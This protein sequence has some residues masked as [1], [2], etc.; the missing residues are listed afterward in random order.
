MAD[1]EYRTVAGFV[2]FDVET[3]EANNQQIRRIVVQSTGSEGSNVTVTLWPE[4]D[5]VEVNRGDFV[6]AN[7]KFEVRPSNKDD[8][9]F[10]N[11]TAARLIVLPS[12]E[13]QDTGTTKK[14]KSGT[15]R[16]F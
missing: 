5:D 9:V 7:G 3:T 14:E 16:P 13:K 1:A 2:Q 15:E 6:V 10:L 4:W 11:M 8:R 12:A